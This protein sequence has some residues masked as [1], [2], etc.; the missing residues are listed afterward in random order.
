MLGFFAGLC[1]F[2][3][4]MFNLAGAYSITSSAVLGM[5]SIWNDT[6]IPQVWHGYVTFIILVFISCLVLIFG[7]RWLPLLNQIGAFLVVGGGLITIIVCAAMSQHA[8]A[9]FVWS[10]FSENNVTGWP[11]GVAFMI[12][13]LNGAY[14]IGTP[15]GV[16]K[17]AEELPNPSHDMPKAIFAQVG[18]G[19]ICK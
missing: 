18:V 16:T 13:V 12:G 3:A 10:N 5:Y 6:Y 1:N 11:N 14:T 9:S 2:F 4:W 19:T 17:L 7:N 8:P 15:D